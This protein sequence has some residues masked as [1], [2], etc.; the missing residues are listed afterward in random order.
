MRGSQV[1]SE[2]QKSLEKRCK[3]SNHSRSVPTAKHMLAVRWSTSTPHVLRKTAS[4][5]SVYQVNEA[6]AMKD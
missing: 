3:R 2:V 4:A 6:E 1:A 5:Q